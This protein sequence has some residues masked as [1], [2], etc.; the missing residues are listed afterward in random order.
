MFAAKM[1]RL[2]GAIVA[3]GLILAVSLAAQTAA[4]DVLTW[5]GGA[6]RDVGCLDQ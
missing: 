3:L 2:L 6:V 5:T 4:A 1:H